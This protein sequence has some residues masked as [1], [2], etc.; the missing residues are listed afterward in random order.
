M[1]LARRFI[2]IVSPAQEPR[3]VR[4]GCPPF[5]FVSTYGSRAARGHVAVHELSAEMNQEVCPGDVAVTAAELRSARVFWRKAL[6]LTLI[7]FASR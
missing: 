5:E 6:S 3:T 2:S 4:S 7:G 1:V